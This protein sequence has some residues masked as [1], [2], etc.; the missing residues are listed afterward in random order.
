MIACIIKLIDII[1]IL[2]DIESLFIGTQ[3]TSMNDGSQ[4][5]YYDE[6]Q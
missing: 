5:C 1:G 2:L 6:P 3:Y 4:L